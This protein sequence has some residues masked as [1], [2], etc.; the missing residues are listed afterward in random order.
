MVLSGDRVPELGNQEPNSRFYS[1]ERAC[2]STESTLVYDFS[3]SSFPLV[4]LSLTCE[5]SYRMERVGRSADKGG[6]S[7]QKTRTVC[8]EKGTRR[9]VTRADIKPHTLLID[10]GDRESFLR[11]KWVEN[12]AQRSTI[13]DETKQIFN[14]QISKI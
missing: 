14:I 1:G 7:G 4:S 8:V 6:E 12:G 9:S 10:N 5:R 13:E 2:E 3:L 11:R